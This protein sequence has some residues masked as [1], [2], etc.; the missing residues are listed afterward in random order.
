MSQLFKALSHKDFALVIQCAGGFVQNQDG[1]VL[2]K[3]PGNGDALLLS[4][5]QLDAALAHIGVVAVLQRKDELFRA[6]QTGGGFDLLPGSA[7]LAVGDVLLHRAA[8]QVHV[9]L[10]DT[11]ILPQALQGD[12]ADVLPVNEDAA[13]GHLVKAGDQ[14]AQGSFAAAGGTH[15]RQTLPGADVQADVVQHLVVVVRVLKAYLLEPYLAGAGLQWHGVRGVLDGNRG[16][17]DLGKALDAG[18]AALELLG[19]LHDAPDGGD[20]SGDVEHIGHKVASG[21]LAVHQRQTARQNDHQI[22]QPVKQA[23]GGVEGAHGVVAKGLDLLKGAVALGKLF[24]LLV[25]GGKGLDHALS[26][27]AVLDGGVQLADLD[28]LLAKP[29]PQ[30]AVQVHRHHAHQRHTGKHCQGQRDAGAA[31]ND[32]GRHDLDARDEKLLRAV[33]GELGHIKQIVGDAPHDGTHLGVVVVGV[34]QLQKMVKGIPAHIRF[35]MHAHDM[36]DAG[37]IVAGCAVDDAQ[38]KVERRQLQHDA[39]R[40]GDAH[41]HGGVGDGA[42]DLGQHDIAQSRQCCAEQIKAQHHLI[43][44][45]IRQKTPDQ[46]TAACVVRPGVIGLSFRHGSSVFIVTFYCNP[47]RRRWRCRCA[48]G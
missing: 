6:R 34:V 36:T 40:Q 21:D 45:Q 16:V 23:G 14:V 41:P 25:L 35:N 7:G 46:R 31:Q 2:Q 3:Y 18:H 20:K 32:K 19:K 28:A 42:H 13:A 1:R 15:Q 39:R 22:H 47:A 30:T 11:D 9:L 38:H 37:H 8:E 29:R 26:Q 44:C 4:A 5:G 48:Q 17:H 24:P 12:P 27:Q 10:Y 43:V 33:V